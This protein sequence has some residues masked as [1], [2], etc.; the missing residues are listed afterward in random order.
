MFKYQNSNKLIEHGVKFSVTILEYM[1]S[2][3]TYHILSVLCGAHLIE[4]LQRGILYGGIMS[5]MSTMPILI[6]VEHTNP[7]DLFYRVWVLNDFNTRMERATAQLSRSSIFGSWVGAFVILLDW[8]RWWQKWPFS[9]CFG[10]FIFFIIV[11]FNLLRLNNFFS[12][13]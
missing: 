6:C 2:I 12:A 10:G 7:F 3:I 5:L 1:G 8:G 9:C 13:H 4:D 11:F